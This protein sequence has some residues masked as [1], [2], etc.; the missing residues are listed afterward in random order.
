VLGSIVGR[1]DLDTGNVWKA[2]ATVAGGLAGGVPGALIGL[3][4]ID[5]AE[6]AAEAVVGEISDHN[7]PYFKAQYRRLTQALARA[8]H[9]M[10]VLSGDIHLGRIAR[11]KVHHEDGRDPTR[12]HEVIASPLTMLDT[13]PVTTQETRN[14]Q[15]H[16]RHFPVDLSLTAPGSAPG[17][18]DYVKHLAAR[19]GDRTPDHFMTLSFTSADEPGS[20]RVSVR[21]W[22]PRSAGTARLPNRAWTYSFNLDEG[23]LP[24]AGPPPNRAVLS[25]M[26]D[27]D[28]DILALCNPLESWSPRLRHEI[29]ADIE[30]GRA[31]YHVAGYPGQQ[32]G[33]TIHVVRDR[34]RNIAY[35]RTN[36][37]EVGVNNLD[38]LPRL[39]PSEWH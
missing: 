36:P 34:V 29:I 15:T 33:A 17:M 20:V 7:L 22:Q 3:F 18:V 12:I 6:D 21:A 35:L 37:D 27:A 2:L 38:N 11:T 13:G 8:P 4:G 14:S 10:L 16:P 31:R 32:P 1:V 5:L 30:S 23:R 24:V 28:G 39:T 26:T 25:V 9:D 19:S